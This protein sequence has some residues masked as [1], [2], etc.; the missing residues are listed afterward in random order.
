MKCS[1]K[2]LLLKGVAV[3]VEAAPGDDV[4]GV[5]MGIEDENILDPNQWR[6]RNILGYAL[7]RVRRLL[8]DDPLPLSGAPHGSTTSSSEKSILRT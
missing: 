5:G 8:R 4:W 1:E 2:V 3:L 6:G 7:M